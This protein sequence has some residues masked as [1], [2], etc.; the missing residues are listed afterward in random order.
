MLSVSIFI[1]LAGFKLAR[2]AA[3]RMEAGALHECSD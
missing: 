2:M 3:R 1:V